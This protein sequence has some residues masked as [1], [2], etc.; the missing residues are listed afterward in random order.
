[1]T[2]NVHGGVLAF[3][4]SIFRAARLQFVNLFFNVNVRFHGYICAQIGLHV[5]I[6]KEKHGAINFALCASEGLQGTS[7]AGRQYHYQ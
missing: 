1:M 3:T 4:S 2:C 5:S 7:L 6:Q